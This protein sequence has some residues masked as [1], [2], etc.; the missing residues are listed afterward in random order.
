MKTS[1]TEIFYEF[2]SLFIDLSDNH[3]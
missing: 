1:N 2:L 3:I